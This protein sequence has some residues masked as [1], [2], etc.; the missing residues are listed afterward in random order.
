MI[1]YIIVI[2]VA[3]VALT[4]LGTLV[5]EDF[6]WW[7][8]ALR[9]VTATV[10]VIALD[11]LTAWLVRLL[12]ERYFS[13]P[14]QFGAGKREIRFY[15]HIGIRAWKEKVP[16]LGLFTKFS[17]SRVEK[18]TDADYLGRFI[19]ECNYGVIIHLVNAVVGFALCAIPFFYP[20]WLIA[21]P[22]A[23]INAILSLLPMFIL[24]Y[25]LPKLAFLH[26]RALKKAER[27]ENS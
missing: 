23:L 2:L 26:G 9:T 7:Q 12:P 18:P 15:R 24:R 27:A 8:V 3:N 25:N 10:G 17:K 13:A 16:E 11:G 22:V 14:R 19:L 4:V 5:V 21:L 6:H 1:L 20:V